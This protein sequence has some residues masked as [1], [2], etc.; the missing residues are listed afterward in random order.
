MN[1]RN[2][3][4]KPQFLTGLILLGLVACGCFSHFGG[5]S[6]WPRVLQVGP[7]VLAAADSLSLRLIHKP[8]TLDQP[9]IVCNSST[10]ELYSDTSCLTIEACLY[11][12]SNLPLL[13]KRW[14]SQPPVPCNWGQSGFCFQVGDS[15]GE[16]AYDLISFTANSKLLSFVVEGKDSACID[17]TNDILG[18]LHLTAKDEPGYYWMVVGYHNWAFQDTT[19]LTWI[20]EVLSD[21]LWIEVTK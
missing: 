19:P 17:I 1:C 21:T 5:K 8:S 3:S 14:V 12:S 20:G 10:F 11:N 4:V 7:E 16:V 18:Y 15:S 6:D 9:A 13:L 2:G